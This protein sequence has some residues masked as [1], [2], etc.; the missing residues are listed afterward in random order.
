MNKPSEK[1]QV[2]LSLGNMGFP[3][4]S[5]SIPAE[6]YGKIHLN[7]PILC[8]DTVVSSD[9]KIFLVRRANEPEK[10]KW[11]FPGGRVVRGESLIGASK[12]IT[13]GEAG[14]S[15][16][17]PQYLG[18]DETIFDADPFGHGQGTHTV[19]FVYA[20]HV[21]ELALFNVILDNNH[22]A[23]KTFKFQEIYESDMHPY[24]KK[25]TAAAEGVFCR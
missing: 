6:L 1:P 19:N 11:W 12:R 22:T 17:K 15:V 5:L 23:Y 24:V 25:F 16:G 8:V 21:A 10:G 18:H 7:M 2:K 20:A 4:R 9:G 13:R 3:D 14:I